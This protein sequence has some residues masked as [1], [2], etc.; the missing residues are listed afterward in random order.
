[1]RQQRKSGEKMAADMAVAMLCE[2]AELEWRL[3]PSTPCREGREARRPLAVLP[4]RFC[5]IFGNFGSAFTS[6]IW[7]R[8]RSLWA[9]TKSSH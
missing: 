4:D 9:A 7:P 6:L 5:Y 3:T 8:C 2:T 1:M